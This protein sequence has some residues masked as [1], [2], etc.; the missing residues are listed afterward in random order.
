M[1]GSMQ[2]ARNDA[3]TIGKEVKASRKRVKPKLIKESALAAGLAAFEALETSE[4]ATRPVQITAR[5]LVREGIESIMRS[6]ARGVPLLRIYGDARK[7]AGLRISFQTFMGYVSEF[8]KEKGLRPAKAM[9]EAGAVPRPGT[10]QG[11]AL[12]G[13]GEAAST[14]DGWGCDRCE[15]ESERRE[16]TKKA[17]TFFWKCPGCGS[18][19]EDNGGQISPKRLRG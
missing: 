13:S 8:S 15:T 2:D 1:E 4:V 11:P 16:S 6:R 18:F 19:H 3:S 10:E 17:G 14:A 12:V 7:A 9:E 5:D